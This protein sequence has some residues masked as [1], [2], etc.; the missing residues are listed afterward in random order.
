M[1]DQPKP[2]FETLYEWPALSG[3]ATRS[4]RVRVVKRNSETPRFDVRWHQYLPPNER[5]VLKKGGWEHGFA[6]N[7]TQ[8]ERLLNIL[9][10]AIKIIKENS[11]NA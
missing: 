9:P 10:E 3:N 11:T 6:W 1:S 4:I 2:R 5:T 8:L 7:L